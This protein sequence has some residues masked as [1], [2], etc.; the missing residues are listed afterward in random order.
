MDCLVLSIFHPGSDCSFNYEF[1]KHPDEE[2]HFSAKVA[3]AFDQYMLKP[4]EL[5][6]PPSSWKTNQSPST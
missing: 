5:S 6:Y 1:A 3:Q 4:Q 2:K